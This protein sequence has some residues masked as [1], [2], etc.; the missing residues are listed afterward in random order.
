[1][2]ISQVGTLQSVAANGA[3]QRAFTSHA[4]GNLVQVATLVG[5]TNTIDGITGAGCGTTWMRVA[6]PYVAF[7]ATL[8]IWAG[9]VGYAT[10]NEPVKVNF[11]S[12]VSGSYVEI[13]VAE[14]TAG[15]GATCQWTTD[16]S[17]GITNNGFS[18]QLLY[19][20]LSPSGDDELYLAHG[21]TNGDNVALGGTTAGFLYQTDAANSQI[22]V[23]LDVS[24]TVQPSGLFR[25]YQQSGALAVLMV[26]SAPAPTI[27]LAS[28]TFAGAGKLNAGSTVVALPSITG[29]TL[30]GTGRF[31]AY[32][33][34]AAPAPPPGS[35]KPPPGGGL[36]PGPPPRNDPTT[37]G[38]TLYDEVATLAVGDADLGYPLRTFVDAGAGYLLQRIDDL[39][40]DTPDGPGWSQTV[41]P[42]RASTEVLPWLGQFV[43][44]PVDTGKSDAA[45]R[46]QIAAKAGFSRGTLPAVAAAANS[47]LVAGQ[48][49]QITERTP[50]AYH[51]TVTVS[52]AAALSK[53]YA[54][55]SVQYGTY[56]ALAAAVPTYNSFIPGTD[57]IRA[58]VQAAKPAGLQFIMVV[59]ATAALMGAGAL[60][61]VARATALATR[62][63]A[64]AGSLAATGIVAVDNALAT[65]GGIGTLAALAKVID[66]N[67]TFRG[68]GALA[69]GAPS[70]TVTEA[71]ALAG[72]GTLTGAAATH[73]PPQLVGAYYVP[74][75]GVNNNTLTTPS[76]TPAPG[77]VLVVKATTDDSGMN[78]GAPSGGGL[79]YSTRSALTAGSNSDTSLFTAVVG[80]SPSAMTVS[81]PFG[82][83]SGGHSMVVERWANAVLPASPAIGAGQSNT[84]CS[85]TVQTVGTNSVVSWV[86]G[87]WN[88]RNPG[89][90][91]TYRGAGTYQEAVQYASG[92]LAAYFAAQPAPTP[93]PQNFGV[94]SPTGQKAS[95]IGIEIQSATP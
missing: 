59:A 69:A 43:G 56:S 87:D 41:D 17:R 50:D 35:D 71:V 84:S 24:A 48:T 54:D 9:T 1:M 39:V 80:A 95:L 93:G 34:V 40:R 25:Y 15:L 19:P 85:L 14:F 36:P 90:S 7:G 22:V 81:L 79:G 5:P 47:V 72:T 77:E 37:A 89:A 64:G 8:E 68:A 73:G 61:A 75:N 63:F 46:A 66:A 78:I 49:V 83:N 12:D 62:I 38:L 10:A 26:P 18:Q 65:L 3:T 16:G 76:F 2:G 53:S 94:S 42:T 20:R 6:G 21:F 60:N 67:P 44:V 91:P 52:T 33:G 74:S 57:K 32:A 88:A 31:L 23:G 70:L 13:D 27:D 58:A 86:A 92:D 29:V 51:F 45:Q 30:L 55:L 4:P 28:V 82:G 11:H